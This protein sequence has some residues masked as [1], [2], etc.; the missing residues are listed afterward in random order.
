[1]A[2]AGFRESLRA[3]GRPPASSKLDQILGTTWQVVRQLLHRLW[4]GGFLS[5]WN[6]GFALDAEGRLQAR[7]SAR[8]AALVYHRLHQL[9]LCSSSSS[10]SGL[11]NGTALA[12]AAVNM[13]EVAGGSMQA[14]TMAEMYV[15]LALRIKESRNAAL[16]FLARYYLGRAR[17]LI[18]R[19]G[20][21]TGT[22]NTPVSLQWL[23]TPHGYRYFL[24]NRWNYVWSDSVFSSL[25]KTG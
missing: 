6:G 16:H 22:G 3:L 8:D 12:L 4:I 9:H 15:A 10:E 18:A 11:L 13:A 7:N 2:A 14:S 25:S 5:R 21:G 1:M 24:A 20:T 23:C 19:D 17:L